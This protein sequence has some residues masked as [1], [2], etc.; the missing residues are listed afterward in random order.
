MIRYQADADLN[1][2]IV[3]AVDRLEPAVDFRTAAEAGLAGLEDPKVLSLAADEGR[4]L[5]THDQRTMPTH[6]GEFVAT[7]RSPGVIVVPQYLPIATAAEGL[8]LIWSASDADEWR[9]RIFWLRR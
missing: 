7:R 6:F 8:V 9:D 4:L 3:R 2:L 1:Q 5:V